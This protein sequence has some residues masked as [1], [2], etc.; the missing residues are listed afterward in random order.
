MLIR[1]GREGQA[2]L[3]TAATI[4][5]AVVSLFTMLYPRVMVSSTGFG[6]SLTIDN[7]ASGHYTLTVMTIVALVLPPIVLL[8][9]AW[10]YHVFRAR[11]GRPRCPPARPTCSVR[12]AASAD[13]RRAR[14]APARSRAPGARR[15]CADAALGLVA[16]LLV[17]AQAVLLARIAARGFDGAALSALTVP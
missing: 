4:V 5:L 10:T 1:A 13:V 11:L 6:N 14:S 8:Y 16:A 17:L 12:G 2:F 9:Q 7:A 3:A 15:A